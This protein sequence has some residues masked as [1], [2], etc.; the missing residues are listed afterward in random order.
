MTITIKK[1]YFDNIETAVKSL[2]NFFG[3][4]YKTKDFP[5]I[6]SN[7]QLDATIL[8]ILSWMN[9]VDPTWIDNS[10]KIESVIERINRFADERDEEDDADVLTQLTNDNNTS[11]LDLINSFIG[12]KMLQMISDHFET[13]NELMNGIFTFELFTKTSK[14]S[15]AINTFSKPVSLDEIIDV[16]GDNQYQIFNEEKYVHGIFD[17]S[18]IKLPKELKL[19]SELKRFTEHQN[20]DNIEINVDTS[21]QEAADINYF[22]DMHPENLRYH[23][24]LKVVQISK[25]FEAKVNQLISG[26]RGCN[27]TDDLKNYFAS[28]PF[29]PDDFTSVVI[30]CILAR[31][32]DNPRKFPNQ[33]FDKAALK[34]YTDSYKSI[35]GKN[36]GAKRFGS[37]DIFSTFKADKEGTIKFIEDFLKL[38][39]VND[40]S[41]MISNNT[42]L[43]TFNIFDSRIYLDIMYNMLPP[44]VRESKAP[45]EDA[46]VKKVRAKINKNSRN[47]NIYKKETPIPEDN[48]LQTSDQVQEYVSKVFL[49]SKDL[50]ISDLMYCEHYHDMVQHEINTLGDTLYN[51][52]VSPEELLEYIGESFD[53]FQEEDDDVYMEEEDA[54]KDAE[55]YGFID[56]S[57]PDYMKTRIK[58]TDNPDKPNANKPV[59][60][61]VQIPPDMPSNS[62][63]ELIDSIDARLNSTD[64]GLD[65]ALGSGYNGPVSK[66][67]G[68]GKVVYNVS[69]NYNNSYN[70]NSNNSDSSLNKNITNTNNTTDSSMNKN[71][72]TTTNTNSNNINSKPLQK[73]YKNNNNNSTV[74]SDTA[75][76][77]TNPPVQPQKEVPNAGTFSNG[78]SVQEVFS[79]LEFG[80]PLS[81]NNSATPPKQD[82]LTKAIDNDRR[83]LPLQQEVK[84]GVQKVG[85]T[86]RMA[87]KPITRAKEWL[88]NMVNSLV[89][90]DEDRV[91]K[92]LLE[93][94]TYRTAIYKAYRIAARLGIGSVLFTLNPY[95]GM[96]YFGWEGL[97]LVDRNRLRKEAQDEIATELKIQD[98]KI[99]QLRHSI[100]WNDNSDDTNAKK[101]QLYQM[102]R[103]RDKMQQMAPESMK[104]F[105]KRGSDL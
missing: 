12:Y 57:I 78:K 10:D 37:Y 14:Y 75:N 103:I 50:S 101:Q 41:G 84:K 23:P 32:F 66:T 16:T 102:I 25:Q 91:K 81:N 55:N 88:S 1:E 93:N 26:L 65:E 80:E 52:C 27:T 3:S 36:D 64:G 92:E 9:N 89:K 8:S 2:N 22:V 7:E 56:G 77:D 54:L 15:T 98:E 19:E 4:D 96:L 39:L 13:F 85:N 43:T 67:G 30:P 60:T 45:S 5:M 79:I 68:E 105:I 11:A 38:R 104:H 20:L 33:D 94:R 44:N 59:V 17:N 97:K 61:D 86:A 49:D 53:I 63:D 46:F 48:S 72:T 42:L 62:Y 29:S 51:H 6:E 99:E 34:K 71:V 73:P 21:V 47:G 76:S 90:R 70:Q 100:Q 87:V 35:L 40:E 95:I 74:L 28:F 82:L 83:T 24:G 18:Q 58:L 31:V 69:Y